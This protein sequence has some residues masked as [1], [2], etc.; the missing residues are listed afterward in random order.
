M[1]SDSF[2]FSYRTSFNVEIS[3]FLLSCKMHSCLAAHRKHPLLMVFSKSN[4]AETFVKR[5][6]LAVSLFLTNSTIIY[7]D[8]EILEKLEVLPQ[9]CTNRDFDERLMNSFND[10]TEINTNS[11]L[12]VLETDGANCKNLNY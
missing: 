8:C 12:M 10:F 2:I 6:R 5:F 1:H 9:L 3:V 11:S 7:L 4:H